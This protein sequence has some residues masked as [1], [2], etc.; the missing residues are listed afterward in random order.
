MKGTG[1]AVFKVRVKSSNISKGKSGGFRVI[2]YLKTATSV[3]L[4]AI[5]IKAERTD[6]SSKEIRRMIEDYEK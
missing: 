6:I 2:Y 3:V 4:L 5:Y 1:H